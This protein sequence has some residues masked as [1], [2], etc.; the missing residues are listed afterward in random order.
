MPELFHAASVEVAVPA[1]DAFAYLSD[2]LRQGEWTLGSW[3]RERVA[4]G[5][6][7]GTS[8]FDGRDV[9]VR[10]TA[11]EPLLLVDYE[12]GPSP[13]RLLRVNAARVVP[14]SL[15]GRAPGS[16]VVTLMKWRT[17]A[18]DDEQWQRACASFDTEIH[19]IK[20]RLELGFRGP[21]PPARGAV[22]DNARLK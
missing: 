2:G 5:L 21:A 17:P 6:F 1:A 7:R 12:V 19:M 18:Q 8:L 14:G 16:C 11:D 13:D 9:F 15:I 4:D 20:G 22:G 3:Q 10:I